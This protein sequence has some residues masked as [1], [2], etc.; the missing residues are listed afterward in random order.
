MGV[1][2]VPT[3]CCNKGATSTEMTCLGG[4]GRGE[5]ALSRTKLHSRRMP[6]T[7]PGFVVWSRWLIASGIRSKI[8]LATRRAISST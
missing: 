6:A 8:E 1:S 5:E 7:L 3:S 4:S 2:L